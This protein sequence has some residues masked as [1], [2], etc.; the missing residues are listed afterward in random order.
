MCLLLHVSGFMD[1]LR[2]ELNLNPDNNIKT[3]TVLPYFV[4]TSAYY[5]HC[6]DIR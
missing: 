3:T 5:M 1:S 4:N 2:E 6:I